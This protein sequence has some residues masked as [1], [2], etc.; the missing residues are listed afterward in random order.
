MAPKSYYSS[1]IAY[2]NAAANINNDIYKLD[3]KLC[4][5][6]IGILADYYD[7]FSSNFALCPRVQFHFPFSLCLNACMR[8]SRLL[9]NAHP[10][11]SVHRIGCVPMALRAVNDIA[12][13]YVD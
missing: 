9:L 13:D 3:R 4:K 11:V 6:E 5:H 12:R 8:P 2:A 10:P 1:G 7:S